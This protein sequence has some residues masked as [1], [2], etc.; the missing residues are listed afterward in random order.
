VTDGTPDV[1]LEPPVP[2]AALTEPDGTLLAVLGHTLTLAVRH[3]RLFLAIA[4]VLVVGEALLVLLLYGVLLPVI[5][6][7]RAGGDS[8]EM[9]QVWE[10]ASGSRKLLATA[11]A[12]LSLLIV[13]WARCA[14]VVGIAAVDAS[15]PIKVLAAYAGVGPRAGLL[16]L[17]QGVLM[18][19]PFVGWLLAM[20]CIPL[21]PASVLE[22][23]GPIGAL[24]NARQ[25]QAYWKSAL[26]WLI[27]VIPVVFGLGF[28]FV[29]ATLLLPARSGVL[30]PALAV[31]GMFAMFVGQLP[32]MA[33]TVAYQRSQA[34]TMTVTRAE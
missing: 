11:V 27:L 16:F 8:V 20:A 31:L 33:A 14:A 6:E 17:T 22:N 12:S 3:A 24:Q 18:F 26:A 2:A 32:I 1:Q 7:L 28:T 5:S 34:R 15:R 30:L 13:P 21:L 25:A 10:R 29:F 19:L 9:I 23:L 4:A